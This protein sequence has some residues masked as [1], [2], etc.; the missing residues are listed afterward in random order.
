MLRVKSDLSIKGASLGGARR[1]WA[2][3]MIAAAIACWF[4]LLRNTCKVNE[5]N[6]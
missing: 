1:W 2:T 5:E 3:S 6:P 4:H